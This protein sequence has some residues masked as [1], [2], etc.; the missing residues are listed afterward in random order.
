MR[1]QGL[2]ALARARLAS[3]GEGGAAA[4]QQG[5]LAST[6]T[7]PGLFGTSGGAARNAPAGRAGA[8]RGAAA[9]L[10][11]AATATAR[12]QPEVLPLTRTDEFGAISILES[13]DLADFVPQSFQNVDGHRIEDGRYAAFAEELT[14]ASAVRACEAWL[15]CRPEVVGWMVGCCQRG[16]VICAAGG[17]AGR[18]PGRRLGSRR[19]AGSRR[20]S[21]RSKEGGISA[22]SGPAAELLDPIPPS[23]PL[24]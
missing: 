14:G 13:Q 18:R 17:S 10:P 7:G 5:R 24:P 22:R 19:A 4:E 20:A 21:R 9:A 2:S 11:A 3:L 1:R 15:V 6:A 12:L 23:P 16:P 8:P